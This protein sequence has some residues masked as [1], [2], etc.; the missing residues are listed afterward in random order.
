MAARAGRWPRVSR[1]KERLR[2]RLK[3]RGFGLTA[4]HLATLLGGEAA[5]APVP[6]DLVREATL[7]TSAAGAG[8]APHVAA[9][10]DELGRGFLLWKALAFG[11][12]A[13]VT[14]A[15]LGAAVTGWRQE[16]LWSERRPSAVLAAA[17][18][19]TAETD[20]P[21][22]LT[23]EPPPAVQAPA[24]K[25]RPFTDE[26]LDVV[27]VA[28]DGRWLSLRQPAGPAAAVEL[29]EATQCQF[30]WVAR[31]HAAPGVGMTAT[32]IFVAEEND[33]R[34]TR[35]HFNGPQGRRKD[36]RPSG[37]PD[38]H[39]PVAEFDGA[40]ELL[41][42]AVARAA[43]E[44]L[45]VAVRLS[46]TTLEVYYRVPPG[47]AVPRAGYRALVW[48]AAGSPDQAAVVFVPQGK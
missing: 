29:G 46:P 43:Q 28:P 9:L 1:A 18:R 37:P 14:S 8:P 41:T 35:I 39:A 36:S 19:P 17:P 26:A 6:H 38:C 10:A 23:A 20:L 2:Q 34:L 45:R 33:R 13:M 25:D 47:G 40:G 30:S 32:R 31:G 12:A 22:F 27:E 4:L 48:L 7:L 11:F 21:P 3:R 44:P 24:G 15:A 42:L 16:N 5:A